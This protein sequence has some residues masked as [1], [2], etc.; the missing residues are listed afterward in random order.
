[1]SD[2]TEL[3]PE[4]KEAEARKQ[5]GL[6]VL[7]RLGGGHTIVELYEALL[8][9]SEEVITTGKKGKVT[10]ELSVHQAT[11]GEPLVTIGEKVRVTVPSRDPKGA[12]LY[13]A[14]GALHA[15][16]PRQTTFVIRSIPGGQP[17]LRTVEVAEPQ[18]RA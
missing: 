10:L 9:V 1:M 3:T 17:E 14:E 7:N 11:Q 16:D 12:F 2:T 6:L 15:N 4:E 13:V 8:R 5:R 18:P